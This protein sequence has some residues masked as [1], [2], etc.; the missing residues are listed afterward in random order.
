MS[1]FISIFLFFSI[2][3]ISSKESDQLYSKSSIPSV[4]ISN[5]FR[6]LEV[7]QKSDKGAQNQS[8]TSYGI[9]CNIKNCQKCGKTNQCEI[10]KNNYKLQDNRCY[11]TKCEIFGFC[12]YCD[13]F[14]CVECKKGYQLNFGTCDKEVNGLKKKLLLGIL[15]PVIFVL[16]TLYIY[17]YIKKK[18]KKIIETGKV[19]NLKHPQPGNYVILPETL[20]EDIT[21]TD[22]FSKS[23]NIS[24]TTNESTDDGADIKDCIVCGKKKVYAFADCGCPLCKEHWK[25]MKNADN[26]K[27]TCRKHGTLLKSVIFSLDNKSNIKG[28]AVER[29][30]LKICPVC[31]INNGTQSF[32]CECNLKICEKCFNDN[33][34]VLKYN[35]CPGCGMPY[36]PKKEKENGFRF[37]RKRN[38]EQQQQSDSESE[39]REKSETMYS[40][41]I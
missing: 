18:N 8:K 30:G 14:D 21:T 2:I 3:I 15:I 1:K 25:Y 27:I 20:R 16:T 17:L 13:E 7:S 28:N 32:N 9:V 23:S 35:Q 29:L 4:N 6:K 5:H 10:C 38:K 22:S 24:H 36:N 19:I 11:N 39:E 40:N 31:K 34:Y 37:G 41:V 12:N 33:V 26:E